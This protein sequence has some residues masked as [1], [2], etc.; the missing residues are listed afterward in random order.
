MPDR[1]EMTKWRLAEVAARGSARL[2]AAANA[3]DVTVQA[4]YRVSRYL[5]KNDQ[6]AALL[7]HKGSTE[8]SRFAAELARQRTGRT[9]IRE[10]TEDEWAV[11]VQMRR[12]GPEPD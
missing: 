3:G 11:V 7:A 8:F 1:S 4:A 12:E 2:I 5:P 6:D 9:V 10:L